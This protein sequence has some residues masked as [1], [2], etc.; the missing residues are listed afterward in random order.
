VLELS[1]RGVLKRRTVRDPG[2]KRRQTVFRADD[3]AAVID[4]Q[5][6]LVALRAGAGEVAAP[7]PLPAIPAPP[8]PHDRPWLTLDE[9]AEYSGLPAS[10]LLQMV[11]D[12][13]LAALD[14]GVRPGGRFR[15][16]R[17]AIDAIEA[18]IGP[19]TAAKSRR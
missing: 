9:A 8:V 3:V 17:R 2:T 7:P 18:P 4:G 12:R 1:A 10:Y 15:I 11:G 13:R 6:R 19:K 5:K 14:V 16:S